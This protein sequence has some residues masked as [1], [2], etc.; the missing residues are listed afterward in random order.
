MN[1]ERGPAKKVLL[2]ISHASVFNACKAT[3]EQRGCSVVED[4]EC[5]EEID[6]VV[7]D[8]FFLATGALE[9]LKH[10]NPDLPHIWITANS[11]LSQA[12]PH[13][14]LCFDKL[15]VPFLDFHEAKRWIL[16]WLETAKAQFLLGHFPREFGSGLWMDVMIQMGA[17]PESMIPARRSA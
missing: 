15:S 2:L 9:W 13:G 1:I 16:S 11:E 7:L 14:H 12:I 4:P 8:S 10:K 17:I 5:L 6:F 3:L